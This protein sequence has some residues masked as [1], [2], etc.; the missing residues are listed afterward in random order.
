MAK[1]PDKKHWIPKNLKK[2]AL[3][4]TLH[5]PKGQKI[6]LAKLQAAAKKPGLEGQRARLAMVFR[7]MGA[8]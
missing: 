6:P 5:A 1:T 8:A 7:H 4:D 2:N 3:R